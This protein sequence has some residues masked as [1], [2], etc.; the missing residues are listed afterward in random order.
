MRRG[1]TT[2]LALVLALALVGRASAQQGGDD[3]TAQ[4]P[5][6]PGVQAGVDVDDLPISVER[7][8]E[9]LQ[10]PPAISLES[11]RPLFRVEIVAT[12]PRWVE[13]IDWTGT[14][15]RIGPNVQI[16]SLHE[17]FIARVTPRE[18]Q[19]FGAFEGAELFQVA[20]TSLLQGLA[21]RKVADRTKDLVRAR[22][23]A[24]ARRAVDAAI[25]RWRQT[26]E[27]ARQNAAREK[28]EA[29]DEGDGGP[30]TGRRN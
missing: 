6:T 10:K 4:E 21:A 1:L 3:R 30:E 19:L 29:E 27:A 16:P 8:E 17:Q 5:G 12:P 23:E 9:N 11:T 26:L 18:A 24:A 28:A 7:I 14:K 25:E 15:D 20:V 13:G 22:R 2:M